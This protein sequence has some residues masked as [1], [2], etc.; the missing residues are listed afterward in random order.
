MKGIYELMTRRNLY[1]IDYVYK[2]HTD[3]GLVENWRWG[4]SG[5]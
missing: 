4:V 2:V 3:V 5:R 1:Q